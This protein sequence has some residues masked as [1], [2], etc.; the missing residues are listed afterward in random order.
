[1]TEGM[2]MGIPDNWKVSLFAK[3]VQQ[4]PLELLAEKLLASG[5]SNLDLTVRPGGYVNPQNV[6]AELPPACELLSAKGIGVNMITTA[7]TDPDSAET[8]KILKTAAACGIEYYKMGYFMYN[9]FGTLRQQ[10][11]ELKETFKRLAGINAKYGIHG[12]YH[13]HSD[14]FFGASLW[15]LMEVIEGTS[16]ETIGVYFDPAHAVIE[17]GSMGWEMAM[18]IAAERITML[19]VKDFFRLDNKLG[20]AGTRRSSVKFCPLEDGEVPWD[21]VIGCLKQINF[22]GPVS[23]HSEYQTSHAFA[24]LSADGVLYQTAKDLKYFADLIDDEPRKD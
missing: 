22:S 4:I 3:H 18:D 8:A 7:I 16:K 11:L 20:Y 17:G 2:I 5:V 21:K 19:A 13:N 24:N 15:D 23:F 14:N 12:G 1:M 6:E 9:G 10:R